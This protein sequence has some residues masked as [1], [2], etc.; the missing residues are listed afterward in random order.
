MRS[1]NPLAAIRYSERA[2]VPL[3]WLLGK[4]PTEGAGERWQQ[5]G[6]ETVGPPAHTSGLRSVS[7]SSAEEIDR[8]ATLMWLEFLSRRRGQ[9]LM[10]AKGVLRVRGGALLIQGVYQ[11][12]EA[13]D[14]PG[15]GP[16][17][18]QLVLIGRGLD[19]EELLRGW[20][21]IGGASA[22]LS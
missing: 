18:S 5:L 20:R 22:S 8:D 1:L 7:L 11:W 17:V 2:V 16:R 4:G 6:E 10:R 13:T 15:D 19:P 9:E 14:E 12:L 3:D 21:A